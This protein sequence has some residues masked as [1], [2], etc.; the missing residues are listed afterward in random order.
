[1]RPARRGDG[2]LGGPPQHR[3]EQPF[4]ERV[5]RQDPGAGIGRCRVPGLGLEA[6]RLDL[7]KAVAE[8]ARHEERLSRHQDA[9]QEVPVKADQR[10]PGGPVFDVDLE[11]SPPAP[12]DRVVGD[13]LD[14]AGGPREADR[15]GQ[16]V[17]DA[18]VL[19]VP[20]QV[21]EQVGDGP[22]AGLGQQLAV[23]G[24]DAL[25]P[26]DGVGQL[27]DVHPWTRPDGAPASVLDLSAV[28]RDLPAAAARPR[29][30]QNGRRCSA[31]ERTPA[32]APPA[33]QDASSSPAVTRSE[34]RYS[35]RPPK[36]RLTHPAS[37]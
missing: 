29:Q 22:D 30:T 9:L 18:A 6:R 1:M 7:L 23:A 3:L 13:H 21:E 33:S 35:K 5:D 2:C 16:G 36:R 12:A 17:Q 11:R 34:G 26:V 28:M 10:R 8:D 15:L 14:D 24:A 25:E 4:G 27:A 20:R 37:G 19:V 31:L 32:I